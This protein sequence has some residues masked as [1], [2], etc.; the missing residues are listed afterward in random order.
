M[1]RPVTGGRAESRPTSRREAPGCQHVLLW[2]LGLAVSTLRW[3]LLTDI[4]LVGYKYTAR[5]S[6]PDSSRNAV[7]QSW[8]SR[9]VS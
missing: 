1:Y 8:G 6:S 7:G 4:R 3:R 2:L 5:V 9:L